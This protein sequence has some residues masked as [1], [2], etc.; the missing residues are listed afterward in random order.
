MRPLASGLRAPCG[1]KRGYAFT[2]PPGEVEAQANAEVRRTF[3]SDWD[4]YF[5]FLTLE[6]FLESREATGQSVVSC[7][8]IDKLHSHVFKHLKSLVPW[9][10]AE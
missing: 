5:Y 8:K 9:F 1:L 6:G 3:W 10:Q 7:F 4:F 2:Y